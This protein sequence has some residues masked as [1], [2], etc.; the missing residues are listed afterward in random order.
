MLANQREGVCC[1]YI[2]SGVKLIRREQQIIIILIIIIVVGA[3]SEGAADCNSLCLIFSL[4]RSIRKSISHTLDFSHLCKKKKK[5][6]KI[7]YLTFKFENF[8]N[9]LMHSPQ[10]CKEQGEKL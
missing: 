6:H 4:N 2:G 9:S 7:S 8:E 1:S 10:I 3:R 5:I